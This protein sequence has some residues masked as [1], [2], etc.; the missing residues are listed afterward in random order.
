MSKFAT[1]LVA[2]IKAK[3]V[4]EQLVIDEVGQLDLLESQL[5]GTT[6]RGEY[7][8]LLAFIQHFANGGNPGKKVKYLK[9]RDGATEYEFRSKHIRICAIQQ[10]GKKLIVYGGFKKAADSSDIIATFR[11]IKNDYLHFLKEQDEKRKTP[12][13]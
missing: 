8:G 7:E 2:E 3:E 6:Y 9:G 12:K 1:K 10:P 5:Q 11:S 13:K 4:V